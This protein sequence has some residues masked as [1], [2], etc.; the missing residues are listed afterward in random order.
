MEVAAQK[1]LHRN[2]ISYLQEG[3][4]IQRRDCGR[5]HTRRRCVNTQKVL[6]GFGN[7]AI[8]LDEYGHGMLDEVGW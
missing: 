7:C 4:R 5:L 3:E 8:V 6:V 2:I 1:W